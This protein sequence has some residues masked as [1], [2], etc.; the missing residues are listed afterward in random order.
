MLWDEYKLPVQKY[1][2]ILTAQGGHCALCERTDVQ[3][4]HDHD[5][6]HFRLL[7]GQHN[8]ALGLLGDTVEAV[9]RALAYLE[10][11]AVNQDNAIRLEI[12]KCRLSQRTRSRAIT[13][14]RMKM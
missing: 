7:C 14:D 3:V 1:D 4:D 10:N 11:H 6:N 5:T 8:H 2:E 13:N 9:R 12:R